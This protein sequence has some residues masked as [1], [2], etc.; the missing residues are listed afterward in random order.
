MMRVTESKAID[1]VIKPPVIK[2]APK[3][4]FYGQVDIDP[5]LAKKQFADL[6]DEVIVNFSSSSSIKVKLT[7]DIQ[8]ESI[9]DEGFD[10]SLQRAIK[11][12]CRVLKFKSSEFE[13]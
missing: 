12:N 6:I 2:E 7:I 11:E 10:E 9:T 3:K 1:Y 4:T 13:E 8:A 5:V